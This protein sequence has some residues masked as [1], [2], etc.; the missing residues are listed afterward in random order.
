MASDPD[1]R[2]MRL[3]SKTLH[4]EQMLEA[5]AQEKK[6]ADEELMDPLLKDEDGPMFPVN[7]DDDR[8]CKGDR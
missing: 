1:R 7:H 6:V 4:R 2:T 5:A 3:L 8:I